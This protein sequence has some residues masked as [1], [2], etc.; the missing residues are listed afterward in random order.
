MRLQKIISFHPLLAASLDLAAGI[1]FLWWMSAIATPSALLVWW[2][3]RGVWW[4]LLTQGMYYPASINPLRHWLALVVFNLGMIFFL[5]FADATV[6]WYALALL[7][8]DIP[9]ISFA[10]VPSQ[11][12]QLSFRGK[13]HRRW[14]FLMT[15]FGVAGLASGAAALVMFQIVSGFAVI[16]LWLGTVLAFGGVSSWW[17]HE[18][19]IRPSKHFFIALVALLSI[20]GEIAFIINLW[21]VGYLIGGFFFTWLWYVLWI[22]LRFSLTVEGINWHKQRIFL[23]TNAGLLIIFLLFVVRWK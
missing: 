12:D 14:R 21:P 15:I 2:V 16:L 7:S 8:I 9:V 18:Y 10:L 20:L 17:W 3:L 4:F 6:L 1:F 11:A 23:F 22:L 19:G 5:L 13:P